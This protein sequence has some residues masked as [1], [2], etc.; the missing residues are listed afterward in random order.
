M[1]NKPILI[2][3]GEPY[4]VFSELIFKVFNSNLVLKIKRPIILI[5]SEKL[6]KIQM[7]KL[8]YKVNIK[9]NTSK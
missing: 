1:I 4:S 9:K 8:G 3:M 5:G 6:L 7:K 2:V